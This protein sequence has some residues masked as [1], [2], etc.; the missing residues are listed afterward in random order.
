[1]AGHRRGAE[2]PSRTPPCS[3]R[4]SIGSTATRSRAGVT[5]AL[6]GA[7]PSADGSWQHI[8]PGGGGTKERSR[9]QRRKGQAAHRAGAAGRRS[10][11]LQGENEEP[12]WSRAPLRSRSCDVMPSA[13]ADRHTDIRRG[14]GAK[15][16]P[17]R[18][19]RRKLQLAGRARGCGAPTRHPSHCWALLPAHGSAP[20][21]WK[22]PPP[23]RP[24]RSVH[25]HRAV[26]PLQ[27]KNKGGEAAPSSGDAPQLPGCSRGHEME[28]AAIG[29]QSPAL[30][31]RCPPRPGTGEGS[32]VQKLA[33]P[34][35]LM[36][37]CS[38]GPLS[39]REGTALQC[40]R[41]ALGSRGD[42]A[43]RGAQ[44]TRG[45]FVA[46]HPAARNALPASPAGTPESRGTACSRDGGGSRG[47]STAHGAQS[48]AG[49]PQRGT[50]FGWGFCDAE[51]HA[52]RSNS[53]SKGWPSH[54]LQGS[55]TALQGEWQWEWQREWQLSALSL[56][57]PALRALQ[58]H[59]GSPEEHTEAWM[60]RKVSLWS[61]RFKIRT[62]VVCWLCFGLVWFFHVSLIK[63]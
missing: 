59:H 51:L 32:L 28:P 17:Q 60:D 13:A 12:L 9:R 16:Q 47:Q 18:L 27:S 24:P 53:I 40:A 3:S 45:P 35:N 54:A 6:P 23:P 63:K 8:G 38:Q 33:R 21:C 31:L 48:N 19:P 37:F 4:P 25:A 10:Q 49:A 22:A 55:H 26:P 56:P 52:V 61:L 20:R 46:L 44:A 57:C 34:I 41:G 1:M 58:G 14:C 36:R 42:L 7:G 15:A 5:L 50:A 39:A 30:L 2:L 29:T 62:V 11:H 43:R